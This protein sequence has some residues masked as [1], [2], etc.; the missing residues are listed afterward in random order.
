MRKENASLWKVKPL[1]TGLCGDYT[2][3][4]CETL[5]G[6]ND[7]ALY[8]DDYAILNTLPTGKS[9]TLAGELEEGSP[10]TLNGEAKSD[11]IASLTNG[12]T[13]DATAAK[14]IPS[15]LESGNADITMAEPEANDE[16]QT[17]PTADEGAGSQKVAQMSEP[18]VT[19]DGEEVTAVTT[20]QISD[21]SSKTIEND[22]SVSSP[23]KEKGTEIISKGKA[24]LVAESMANQ[25][26]NVGQSLVV[27]SERGLEAVERNGVKAPSL[28]S[29]AIDELFVHP[30]FLPPANA[31][32]DRDIGL[33]E[34]EAEDIRRLLTLYVQKQEEVC[35]G[36]KRLYEGLLRADRLRKTVFGWAKAEAHC[37]PNREMSDGEDWYDKEEWGL[38]DDL[39][40]GQDEEEEDTGATAKKTRNRR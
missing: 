34:H 11:Q 37:G 8:S 38:V 24:L 28:T 1:L 39:K 5:I 10:A 36:S 12:E 9:L 31:K 20:T 17:K 13:G 25:E 2:W 26:D 18:G 32:P 40:K 7:L 19:E 15:G 3:V 22:N 27:A 16:G 35:R 30:F 6:L 4:P 14:E 21:Q 29:E 33:P 23:G